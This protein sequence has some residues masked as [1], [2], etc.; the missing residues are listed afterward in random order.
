MHFDQGQSDITPYLVYFDQG[1]S[2]ITPY[3]VHLEL[4]LYSQLVSW[5]L[6]NISYL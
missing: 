5:L 2:D 1:Q 3:L 4:K 6:P